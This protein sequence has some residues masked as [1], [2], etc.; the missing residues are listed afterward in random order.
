MRASGLVRPRSTVDFGDTG[1]ANGGSKPIDLTSYPNWTEARAQGWQGKIEWLDDYGYI[2]TR[3]D[4][5]MALSE[6][7]N[8]KSRYLDVVNFRG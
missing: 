4:S 2:L 1:R 3:S 5:I 7:S 6:E 8:G